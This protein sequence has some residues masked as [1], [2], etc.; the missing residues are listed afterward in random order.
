[1]LRDAPLSTALLSTRRKAALR[2]MRVTLICHG[3]TAATRMAAFPRDEPLDARALEQA[4]ALRDAVPHEVRALSSPALRARQTAQALG[5]HAD[6]EAALRE[7]DF[8]RWAGRSLKD[9]QA[10]GPEAIALWLGDVAAAPHGGEPFSAVFQR[11]SAWLK[12]AMSGDRDIVA[13]THSTVIRAAIVHVLAAPANSFWRID[14]E[15]LSIVELSG[16]GQSRQLRLVPRGALIRR[17][18]KGC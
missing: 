16:R 9:V 4:A 8:G 5:L 7:C 18:P 14:V 13:V 11:V 6:S 15:P 12:Q 10:A 2:K 1:M 3:A 17:G